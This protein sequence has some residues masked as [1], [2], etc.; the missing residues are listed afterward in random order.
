M[1]RLHGIDFTAGY[2]FVFWVPDN[3]WCYDY[4][5]T[6]RAA[7]L[8]QRGVEIT[9]R[10]LDRLAVEVEIEDAEQTIRYFRYLLKAYPDNEAVYRIGLEKREARLPE[11]RAK[12]RQLEATP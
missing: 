8:G 4:K 7:T 6:T 12:L 3:F 9:T 10:L 5:V 2:G 11:L 1:K